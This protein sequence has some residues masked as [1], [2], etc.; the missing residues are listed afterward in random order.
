[1]FACVYVCVYI[2]IYIYIYIHT[3]VYN[4]RQVLN[5]LMVPMSVFSV[6][7]CLKI[8]EE[9]NKLTIHCP[10]YTRLKIPEIKLAVRYLI[11]NFFPAIKTQILEEKIFASK[12]NK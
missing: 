10:I 1:M 5:M 3:R 12:A 2:Y 7:C 8:N 4:R 6:P 11:F 9:I